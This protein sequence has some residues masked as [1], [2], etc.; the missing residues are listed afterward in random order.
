MSQDQEHSVAP[1]SPRGERNMGDNLLEQPS[2]S[3]YTEPFSRIEAVS[4]K[5]L[6]WAGKV[7]ETYGFPAVS[8]STHST[9]MIRE[10]GS[11]CDK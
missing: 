3:Y 10:N 7:L 1:D 9:K 11:H 6:F 4:L 2:D 5:A 8:Q